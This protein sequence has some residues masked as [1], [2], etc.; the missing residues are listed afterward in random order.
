MSD[1]FHHRRVFQRHKFSQKWDLEGNTSVF[2]IVSPSCFSSLSLLL[3]KQNSLPRKIT[4]ILDIPCLLMRFNFICLPWLEVELVNFV[5]VTEAETRKRRERQF[6]GSISPSHW[7]VSHHF[8][9]CFASDL[10]PRFGFCL[11]LQ[12]N[13]SL[14]LLNFREHTTTTTSRPKRTS[15]PRQFSPLICCQETDRGLFVF[16]LNFC[17]FSSPITCFPSVTLEC[18]RQQFIIRCQMIESD[19]LETT[20]RSGRRSSKTSVVVYIDWSNNKE[21]R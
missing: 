5:P 4:K 19:P 1:L 16:L 9:L 18:T 14:S 6:W 20:K 21:I 13:F 7:L 8:F 10:E 15:S 3:K 11:L 17:L 2:L 12:L